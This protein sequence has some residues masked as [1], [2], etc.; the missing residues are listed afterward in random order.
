MYH[1]SSVVVAVLVIS[2]LI[3]PYTTSVSNFA[4]VVVELVGLVEVVVVVE[5]LSFVVPQICFSF[6]PSSLVQHR[7]LSWF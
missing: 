6:S 2:S 7:L 1:S 3:V 5:F 4:V